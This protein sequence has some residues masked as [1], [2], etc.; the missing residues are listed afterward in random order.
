MNCLTWNSTSPFST[1]EELR[2]EGVGTVVTVG[3]GVV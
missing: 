3:R 2:R 1:N